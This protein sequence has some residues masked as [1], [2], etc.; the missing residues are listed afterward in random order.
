MKKNIAVVYG[1]YSSEHKISVQS[2]EYIASIID[3]KKYNVYKILLTKEKW[4][5]KNNNSEINKKD[6]SFIQ[7]SKK[8]NFDIVVILIHGTPGEDGILQAYLHTVKI[9]YIESNDMV[10]WITFEKYEC[11]RFLKNYKINIASSHLYD[12]NYDQEI[13]ST[14]IIKKVGL[15]CFVKPNMGGSSFG[16]SKVKTINELEP[17]INLATQESDKVIIEEYIEGREITCALV[18]VKDELRLF[19]LCEIISKNEFFDYEA[20][21]N[22]EKNEE[23]VPAGISE[24]LSKLCWLT[25]HHIYNYLNCSGIVRIDYILKGN[26]FYFLEVN[27]IPGMTSESLVPKMIKYAKIDLTKLYTELIE[28]ILN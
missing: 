27:T 19:P 20:K 3:K 23:I 26:K 12:K 28:N 24:E 15:P 18:R 2:G 14:E 10:S 4:L 21:Y 6:F 17:A 9:P 8:V 25:S 1:G 13:N 7:D 5:C 22:S 16:I 11:N